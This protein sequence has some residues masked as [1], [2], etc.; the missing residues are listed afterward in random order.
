ML[1]PE[2]RRRE[3]SP[4][5]KC[6]FLHAVALNENRELEELQVLRTLPLTKSRALSAGS[7]Q[8]AES[9]S[10]PPSS[11][12][13][14]CIN[15]S[16]RSATMSF[17]KPVI[18]SLS[19]CSSL[20]SV[21]R[22]SARIF[23]PSTTCIHRRTAVTGTSAN[24]AKYRRQDTNAPKKKKK[25]RNDFVQYDLKDAEQFALCDAMRYARNL[26]CQFFTHA[27]IFPHS[28]IRA[29]EVGRPPTTP[30]YELAI[31]LRTLKNGPVVRNRLRLP[32]PI[33]TDTRIAVIMP[34]DHPTAAAVRE[35]GATMVGDDSI[36]TAVKEGRVEFDRCI[37]H[38]DS[39]QKLAK[40][41]IG[42]I[43]GPR[44]LMPSS[45]TGTV[46]K[47]VAKLIKEMIGGSEYREKLGVVRLSVGQ[48]A[49]TPAMLRN[50]IGAVMENVR[51]DIA[52]LSDTISKDVHEVVLSSTQSPG[53]SLAGT[54]MRE[55][56]MTPDD[57]SEEAHMSAGA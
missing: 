56:G 6:E 34:P 18:T 22:P 30:K 11:P 10:T 37:C 19:S 55:G 14:I 26:S 48:L 44:G 20:Q 43:L 3:Q 31:K 39:Q 42:R 13:D 25:Q 16:R 57:L 4:H 27:N 36:I 24:A 5:L 50:N 49:F 23:N 1:A 2:I 35:A 17:P 33:K 15:L 52:Q 32:H 21:S 40:S 9:S 46:T 47:D 7:W 45:K 12:R 29:F 53:F 51:R 38:T 54:F 8:S 41:G 28:Y